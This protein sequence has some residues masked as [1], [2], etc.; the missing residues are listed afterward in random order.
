MGHPDAADGLLRYL[1]GIFDEMFRALH[2]IF[3]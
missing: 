1:F 3:E 2:I